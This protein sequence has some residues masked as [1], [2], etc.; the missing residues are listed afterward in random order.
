MTAQQAPSPRIARQAPVWLPGTIQIA[1]QKP[2][3]TKL[4]QRLCEHDDQQQ[5]R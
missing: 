2:H 5:A 1:F 3:C 4:T